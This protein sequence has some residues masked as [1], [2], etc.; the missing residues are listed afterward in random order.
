MDPVLCEDRFPA[1]LAVKGRDRNS[2]D[3]LPAD[4]PVRAV[5]DHVVDPL[6]APFRDPP[7]VLFDALQGILPE[8]GDG[9]KPLV[10]R[11]ED[12]RFFASPA[13]RI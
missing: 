6:L 7:N 10:S 1:I 9:D 13:V 2:P 11:P 12:D 4:T 8:V 5:T 3:P